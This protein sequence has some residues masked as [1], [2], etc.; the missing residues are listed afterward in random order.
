MTQPDKS[1]P[2]EAA[3]PPPLSPVLA[4]LLLA[5]R[6]EGGLLVSRSATPQRARREAE[7]ALDLLVDGLIGPHRAAMQTLNQSSDVILVTYYPLNPDFTVRDPETAFGTDLDRLCRAYPK[8]PIVYLEAG[9]PTSAGRTRASTARA[10]SSD[11]WSRTTSGT[12]AR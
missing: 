6:R 9:C 3:A 8:R 5:A 11:A 10:S 1:F 7:E 4:A 12:S 2:R